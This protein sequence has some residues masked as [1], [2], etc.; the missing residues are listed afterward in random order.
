MSNEPTFKPSNHP[1]H[2]PSWV[3]FTQLSF[4]IA[5]AAMTAGIL[6]L[7][8]DLATR[9][10][11]GMGSLLVIITSINMSKTIRDQHEADRLTNKVEDARISDFLMKHDPLV[12]S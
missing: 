3:M 5:L 11:L 1:V 2:S 9:G 8:I 12:N 6:L 4:A 10:Y 7:D